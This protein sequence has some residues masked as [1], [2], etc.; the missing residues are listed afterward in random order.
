[1]ASIRKR[2]RKDGGTTFAVLYNLDGRQT[3]APFADELDAEKF[4][5]LVNSVGGRRAQ[6]AWGIADAV[7]VLLLDQTVGEWLTHYIDHLTGVEA[8]TRSEYRRFAERDLKSLAALPLAS[9]SRDDIAGWVNGLKGSAKTVANKH[10]FLAGALKEAAR[11]HKIPA[12]PSDGIRLPRGQRADMVFLTRDEYRAIAAELPEHHRPLA[13]FLVASGARFSEATALTPADIDR[14]ACTVRISKAWKQIPGSGYE[15]GAP[16][17]AKSVRTINVPKAVLDQL[18]YSRELVFTNH[19]GNPQHIH[20]WRTHVWYP[21]VARAQAAKK[22]TKT[23]NVHSMRHTCVSW[24]IA[25]GVPLPAIQLHLG[26]ESIKTTIDRYGHLDRTA[27]VDV[28]NAIAAALA[29]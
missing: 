20:V 22:L 17:T 29:N 21:A 7:K 6:D 19:H 14:E 5:D 27:G 26:H 10:G 4:R 28:A 8:R 1:M 18:D 16:K 24:L 13:E 23:P 3:S 11:Q 25:A 12:N 15:L 9:L 2:P